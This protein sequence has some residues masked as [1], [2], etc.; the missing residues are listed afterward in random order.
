MRLAI[1]GDIARFAAPLAIG[2]DLPLGA[3]AEKLA[4]VSGSGHQKQINKVSK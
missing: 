2:C 1:V 4:R 3:V